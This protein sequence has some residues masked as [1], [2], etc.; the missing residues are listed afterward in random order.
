M[1][2]TSASPL[3]EGWRPAGGGLSLRDPFVTNIVATVDGR[4]KKGVIE[5]YERER[6]AAVRGRLVGAALGPFGTRPGLDVAVPG[7]ELL[8]S[9]AVAGSPYMLRFQNAYVNV[10]VTRSKIVPALRFAFT[11]YAA[12]AEAPERLEAM[13][14]AISAELLDADHVRR[15]SRVGMALDLECSWFEPPAEGDVITRARAVTRVHPPHLATP[16]FGSGSGGTEFGIYDPI[17][18][19]NPELKEW[20]GRTVGEDPCDGLRVWRAEF[21]FHRPAIRELNLGRRGSAGNGQETIPALARSLEGLMKGALGD[22]KDRPW[23]RIAAAGPAG[24]EPSR[25]PDAWWWEAVRGA[26]L[27][28]SEPR[29]SEIGTPK[30]TTVLRGWRRLLDGVAAV[31][32]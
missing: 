21:C 1:T 5:R 26:F 23:V 24:S 14:G 17:V 2:T 8:T 7:G 13:I 28:G 11:P 25:R 12:Y 32:A 22:S 20:P 6:D 31:R 19:A 15:I 9:P 10:W 16:I 3:N 29:P 30:A 4:L 27:A 18:L